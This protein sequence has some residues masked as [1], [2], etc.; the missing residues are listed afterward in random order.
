MHTIHVRLSQ[1]FYNVLW[2]SILIKFA[3]REWTPSCDHMT[4]SFSQHRYGIFLCCL[5]QLKA[6]KDLF[7]YNHFIFIV[8]VFHFH[9]H[10]FMEML[11]SEIIRY[12]GI[13]WT[14]C[15]VHSNIVLL[16]LA[17][18]T[19]IFLLCR[20]HHFILFTYCYDTIFALVAYHFW[21]DKLVVEY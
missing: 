9:F 5:V 19:I 11:H 3:I 14:M 20:L 18:L 2:I 17:E 7:K 21:K 12:L 13:E 15:S 16:I 4:D 10:L 6:L 1:D 8:S